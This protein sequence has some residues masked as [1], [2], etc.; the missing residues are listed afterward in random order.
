MYDRLGI[1]PNASHWGVCSEF[2]NYKKANQRIS[3]LFPHH[4]YNCLVKDLI[5]VSI[6]ALDL[7]N[8]CLL[9]S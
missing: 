6:L 7:T 5:L 1:V 8:E 4:L 9:E 3:W 2:L